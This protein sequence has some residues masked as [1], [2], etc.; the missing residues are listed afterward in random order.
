MKIRT[1]EINDLDRLYVFYNT[2]I[3]H[4]ELD[5]YGPDWTKDVYPSKDDLESFIKN[6]HLYIYEED[7]NIACAC[8]IRLH[9]DE[10]YLKAE[11]SRKLKEDEIGVL[12]LFA[13][14]PDYRRKGYS[15]AFLKYVIEDHKNKIKAIHLDVVKGNLP[16]FRLY[17]EA[18]F[19]YIGEYEVYYA[20]TGTIT[21][22]LMEYNY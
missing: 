1:A 5:E 17:Q 18:G 9:E 11:W 4:Q 8:A 20:D 19:T 21:V 3:D 12:H 6:D 15:K 13:V 7:N 22:D 16:A 14:H 2:V 10:I